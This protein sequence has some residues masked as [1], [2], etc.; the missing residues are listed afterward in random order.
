MPNCRQISKSHTISVRI[1]LVIKLIQSLNQSFTNRILIR[2]LDKSAVLFSRCLKNGKVSTENSG[3]R[4]IVCQYKGFCIINKT[5]K[6]VPTAVPTAG[7]N[8]A[9]WLSSCKVR[10]C[11]FCAEISDSWC[12]AETQTMLVFLDGK[13]TCFFAVCLL[14]GH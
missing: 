1:M 9:Q 7:L 4:E 8:K 14:W 5:K 6:Q 3:N 12:E 11:Y 2:F 10:S 13:Y